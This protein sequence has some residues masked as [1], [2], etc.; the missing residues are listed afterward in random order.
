[1]SREVEPSIIDYARFHGLTRDYLAE[2]PLQNITA[3]PDFLSDLEDNENLFQIRADCVKV[4]DE[5]L[6]VDEDAASY[7]SSVFALAEE[8]PSRN[9][10]IDEIDR[11]RFRRMKL[12]V[13][14]LRSDPEIDLWRFTQQIVPDLGH[15]FLPLETVDQEADEGLDWPTKYH[16]LPEEYTR[17]IKE[18]K[19]EVT[20]DTL[21]FLQEALNYHHEGGE[22]EVFEGVELPYTKVCQI[23]RRLIDT[24]TTRENQG[25]AIVSTF[26]AYVP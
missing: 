3:P 23:S 1:M 12:E 8:P 4:P 11:H 19:L 22:H 9:D 17:R 24:N 16:D 6:T 2:D 7:L 26:T 13:P 20:S 5:R 25:P 14:L 18:E 21:T 10:D 15:E